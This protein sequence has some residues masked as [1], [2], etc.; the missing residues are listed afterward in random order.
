M[1]NPTIGYG[2]FTISY[3]N[4][5]SKE[6]FQVGISPN[7]SGMSVYILGIKDRGY[8]PAT[9]SKT[10]GKATVTGYCVKF[11]KLADLNLDVLDEAILYGLKTSVADA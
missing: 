8:L 11:K 4:G 9:Y 1:T 2:S 10:I 7:K 5:T 3:A 6:F